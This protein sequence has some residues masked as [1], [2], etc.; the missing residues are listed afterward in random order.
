MSQRVDAWCKHHGIYDLDRHHPIHWLPLPVPI[1][2][3]E[4]SSALAEFAAERQAKLVIIDTLARCALGADENSARDMGM[5]IEGMDRVRRATG[6]CVK[7]VHHSGKDLTAG[8]RGNSA[9]KGAMDTELEL[10]G[11]EDRCTLKMPKQ[12]DGRELGPMHFRRIEVG[13][14]CVLIPAKAFDP[15][16]GVSVGALATLDT[17]RQIQ[18]AGGVSAAAWRV[19]AT[20]GERAFYVHRKQ[21]LDAGLVENIGT[22]KTPRYQAKHDEV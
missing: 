2:Q 9:L 15:S 8:A 19:A 21:L 12:K 7:I 11:T 10:T 5:F 4:W 3:P 1:H 22:D 6:A 18:V 14:S 13:E 20:A 16:D 17:L